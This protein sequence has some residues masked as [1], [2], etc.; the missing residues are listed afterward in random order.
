MNRLSCYVRARL[1]R[2]LF[3]WFGMAILLSGVV[4]SLVTMAFSASSGAGWNHEVA[5]VRVFVGGRFA[6][7]WDDAPA[8]EELARAM[9]R[10]L[11]VTV[12]LV[13]TGGQTLGAYGRPCHHRPWFDAQ[14]TRAGRALGAVLIC[15]ER[16]RP[17]GAF[18]WIA[19]LLLAGAVLWGLSG[20]VSRRLSRPLE[21]L[22]RMASEIGRG[23]Y[24]SRVRIGRHGH[25]EVL[26][27]ADAMNDMASRIERQMSDQRELLA[28]VSHEMR[29]PLARI[30]IL[31]ELARDGVDIEKQLDDLDREVVEMD[32]LVGDL[33]ASSRLDFT[34]LAKESIDSVD[35]ARR[36]LERAGLGQ[37]KLVVDGE[38]REC[39]A[40]PTLLARALANLLD[41]AKKHGGGVVRLRVTCARDEV[42]FDVED[43]GRGLAPGEETRIFEP[44]YR[45][46]DEKAREQGSLGLGLSL[47]SRIAEAHGGRARAENRKEGGARI[48][49]SI[50]ASS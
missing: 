45:R 27:L 42:A 44:F 30:R 11:E 40:D 20:M 47:V 8:R 10:E 46:P 41:N 19:P 17:F 36:A 22:A 7:V 29:T 2:R 37:D 31:T 6:D 33:L 28:A 18:R 34:A 24:A 32:A 1:Q 26:V 13:D 48:G 3:L 43:A 25:G 16:P 50:P 38:R 49:F 35:A 15:A 12:T 9:S 23:K 5:R 4:F 39:L 14:V 21:E